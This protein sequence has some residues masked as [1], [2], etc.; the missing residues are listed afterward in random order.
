VSATFQTK[1]FAAA[2]TSAV[3]ALA[4]AGGLVA[5]LMRSRMDE[6]IEATLAAQTKLAADLVTRGAPGLTVEQLDAEADRLGQLTGTRVTLIAPDGRVMGDSSETLEGVA[7]ME[8]HGQRPEV[9]QARASGM[10][11]AQRHSDTLNIDMLYVA[12]RLQHPAV[13]F[14]RMALPLTTVRQQLQSAFTVT[15]QA[16]ALA[17]V[18]AVLIA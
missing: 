18:G 7:A 13:A 6:Q 12:V 14:V 17:L 10:G 4:V 8:N 15:L 5:T 1:F 2:L 11:K 9:V 3:I 16:L